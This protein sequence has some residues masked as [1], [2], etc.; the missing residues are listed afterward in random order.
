[1]EKEIKWKTAITDDSDGAGRIRGYKIED[2]IS[3]KSFV[4]T[5]W[6][7]LRGELPNENETALFNAILVSVSDHGI[8]V[9]SVVA[10]RVTA[11]GG[12]PINASIAAGVLACGDSHGGAI[13]GCMK[14]L[15]ETSKISSDAKIAAKIIVEKFEAENLRIHGYG[16]KILQTDPRSAK[17][18]YLARKLNAGEKYCELAEAIGA[19]LSTRQGRALPLNVDGAAAAL[20]LSLGFPNEAGKA[21]FIIGRVAGISAH[22]MEEKQRE[23]PFRRLQKE[24]YT[25]DGVAP[26][27][28]PKI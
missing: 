1:M 13:E 19:E 14:M 28:L 2:L 11:S 25:Y 9:P 17:L 8:A 26:R 20:L 16:H 27:D 7:L 22:V 15:E 10:A 6:L 4:E 24:E 3:G 18:F 21:I 23:K 12:N 5:V